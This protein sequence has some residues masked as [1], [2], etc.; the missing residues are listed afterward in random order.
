MLPYLIYAQCKL[1]TTFFKN[2]Y[3][4]VFRK[5][6]DGKAPNRNRILYKMPLAR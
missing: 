3:D 6:N 5:Y 2:I 4:I 1:R